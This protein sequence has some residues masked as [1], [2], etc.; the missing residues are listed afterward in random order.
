MQM[1]KPD[2]T[3]L[4]CVSHRVVEFFFIHLELGPR[5]AGT[6]AALA[7]RVRSD[8]KGAFQIPRRVS[9]RVVSI[10]SHWMSGYEHGKGTRCH[11][12]CAKPA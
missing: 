9:I 8:S 7:K 6:D 11:D 12:R 1:Q 2:R 3:H 4:V 10:S 5:S